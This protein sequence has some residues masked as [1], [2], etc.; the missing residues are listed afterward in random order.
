MICYTTQF[1]KASQIPL[2]RGTNKR[3]RSRVN[4]NL[5]RAPQ[6]PQLPPGRSTAYWSSSSSLAHNNNNRGDRMRKPRMNCLETAA[7]P[8]SLT[9]GTGHQDGRTEIR[10]RGAVRRPAVRRS[11]CSRLHQSATSCLTEM[12]VRRYPEI[13]GALL[14]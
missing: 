3:Y 4:L 1:S 14:A 5:T 8:E 7:D 10:P 2:Y 11:R 6:Q 13:V 9:H 12:Q